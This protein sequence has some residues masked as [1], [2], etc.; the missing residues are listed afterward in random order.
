MKTVQ[1]RYSQVRTVRE[2]NI[3]AIVLTPESSTSFRLPHLFPMTSVKV[4]GRIMRRMLSA[5]APPPW[6]FF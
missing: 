4:I 3:E 6:A 1:D 5:N 2:T